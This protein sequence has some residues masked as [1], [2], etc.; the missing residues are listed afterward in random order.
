MGMPLEKH[1]CDRCGIEISVFCIYPDSERKER[2]IELICDACAEKGEFKMSE[3]TWPCL[4]ILRS[5]VDGSK[6]FKGAWYYIHDLVDI[7]SDVHVND[8]VICCHYCGAKR[9]EEPKPFWEVLALVLTNTTFTTRGHKNITIVAI[10]W[11][12]D[13]LSKLHCD[14]GGDE[15]FRDRL[16]CLLREEIEKCK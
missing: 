14:S 7:L 10:E 1:P 8:D 5:G 16:Y 3:E 9:P 15:Y 4:H 12:I 6:P 11:F 13:F 2:G